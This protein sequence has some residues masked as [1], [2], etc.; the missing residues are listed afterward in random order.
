MNDR[1]RKEG[2]HFV[3]LSIPTKEYTF[4]KVS[5]LED[6]TYLKLIAFEKQMWKKTFSFFDKYQIPYLKSI[7]GLEHALDVG[8]QPFHASRDGHINTAGHRIIAD[9]ILD[10]I[11]RHE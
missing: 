4:R 8:V 9:E 7:E 10:F 5:K 2:K 11:R 6:E 1:A 3:V